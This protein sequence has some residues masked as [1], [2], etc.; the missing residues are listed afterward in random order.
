MHLVRVH[1]MAVAVLG[2]ALRLTLQDTEYNA[3]VRMPSHQFQRICRDLSQFGDSVLIT[4]TKDGVQF[5]SSGD[6]GSGKVELRQSA[7][8]DKES[9]EVRSGVVGV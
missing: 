4:C 3:V 8:I 9:E 5:S 1:T 2:D 7:S 6:I